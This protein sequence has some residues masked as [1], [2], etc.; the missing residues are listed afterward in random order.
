MDRLQ[1]QISGGWVRNVLK[2]LPIEPEEFYNEFYGEAIERIKKAVQS[3]QP[4]RHQ[5]I[6][7]DLACTATATEGRIT[8][9]LGS[10]TW[11]EI[12]KR[13]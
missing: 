3:L 9:C 4:T 1:E 2:G 8:A 6:S 5:R 12:C 7:L 13:A 10:N 11:Q